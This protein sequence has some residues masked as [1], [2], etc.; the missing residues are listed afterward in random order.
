MSVISVI[1][2]EK[3]IGKK[4]GRNLN[5]GKR[6]R[7]KLLETVQLEDLEHYFKYYLYSKKE[8]Q[9]MLLRQSKQKICSN[10][11]MREIPGVG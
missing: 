1:G 9:Q 10:L 8:L 6:R 11:N 2:M 5:T 3:D 7:A 4:Y